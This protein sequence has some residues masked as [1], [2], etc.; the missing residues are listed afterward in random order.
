MSK[1][2]FITLLVLIIVIGSF[3][4]IN[5]SRT[6]EEVIGVKHQDQGQK[7]IKAGDSHETYNSNLPSSGSHY[8]D[9]GSPIAWGIYTKEIAPEVFL[10]NEEH[11]GVVIAYNPNTLSAEKTSLLQG[12]FASPFSNKS[13]VPRKYILMPR[14]GNIAAIQLASWNYTLDLGTY[15][16]ATIVKFF[17]QHAGKAPE[18]RAGPTNTPINQ[19]THLSD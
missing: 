14:E 12:L 15:D 2:F 6:K 17:N 7:H 5:Q 19:V 8:N 1:P 10:H 13:F 16:E 18:P 11:G 9:A 4:F 3:I